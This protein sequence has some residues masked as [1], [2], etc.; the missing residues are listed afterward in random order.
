[1]KNRP[2]IIIDPQAHKKLNPSLSLV[3]NLHM[4]LLLQQVLNQDEEWESYC[5][6][7]R[8]IK[9]LFLT[10]FLKVENHHLNLNFP[11]TIITHKF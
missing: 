8:F 11:N 10:K 6:F 7:K 2:L 5:A 1:M 3:L 4:L 9:A